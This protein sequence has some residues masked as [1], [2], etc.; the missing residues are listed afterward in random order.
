MTADRPFVTAVVSLFRPDAEV[1]ARVR[2]LLAEVDAVVAVDDSPDPAAHEAARAEL[3]EAGIDV[4]VVGQNSGIAHALN[5]GMARARARRAGT[6]LL[7]MDQD[8]TLP[9]GYV[10][11][12]LAAHG[13]ATAAGLAVGA[14]CPEYLGHAPTPDEGE[15]HGFS[16]A[17]DPIQSA[18][19][20]APGTIERCGDLR[21]NYFIDAVDS[22]YTLRMRRAG[23]LV[24]RAPG[25]RLTHTMGTPR[26]MRFLGRQLTRG[27]RP[28]NVPYQRPFRVYYI[29]RNL[30]LLT[31]EYGREFPK[32]LARRWR[33]EVLH[34]VAR[35][36]W[37]P[38]RA[39]LLLAHAAGAADFVRRRTGRIPDRLARRLAV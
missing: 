25:T 24:V 9:S 18:L 22:E 27:G 26:P 21:E 32:W 7:T 20:I 3:T 37:G 8:S 23:L 11:A 36:V 17:Y 29:A 14:V 35:V 38:D 2:G 34:G 15:R 1:A 13:G 30:L 6:W 33:A 39:K 12:A 10:D 16:L 4:I 31:A 5:V 28:V 19:L